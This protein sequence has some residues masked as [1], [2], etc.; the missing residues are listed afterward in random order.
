MFNFI[1]FRHYEHGALSIYNSE[2]ITIRN[3][4]FYN[5]TS[6][7]YFSTLPFRGSAGGI[8]IGYQ[9][10]LPFRRLNVNI[11]IS[12]CIFTHNSATLLKLGN[13]EVSSG[14]VLLN[15][16]FSGRGGALAIVVYTNSP[17]NFVFNNSLV[18]NNFAEVIGGGV[19]CFAQSDFSEQTYLFLMTLL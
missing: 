17:L 8:S 10:V 7:G 15:G 19:Y 6:D 4:T 11:L 5:N 3:C 2:K 16:K 18:I 12:N 9:T 1:T 14:E 13:Q